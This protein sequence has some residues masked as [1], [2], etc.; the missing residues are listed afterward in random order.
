MIPLRELD[1]HLNKREFRDAI[2]LRYD[3]EITDTPMLSACVDHAMVCL[4][5]GYIIQRHN[6]LRDLEAEMLGMVCNDVE[7]ELVLQEVTGETLN[8]GANKA[9]DS[10]SRFLGETEIC[11]LGLLGV[12]P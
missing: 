10:W 2:K 4:R 11:I 6:G 1:Y 7:V 5:G 8:H 9:P 12:S 3:W